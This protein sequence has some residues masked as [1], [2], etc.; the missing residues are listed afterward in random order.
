[1]SEFAGE[2]R[3]LLGAQLGIWFG[4]LLGPEDPVYTEGE[5]LEIHGDLDLDIFGAAL[6]RT[7]DE[8]DFYHLRFCG[9]DESPR[10]Y[11]DRRD[12]W[13]L[14]VIDVSAAADP[15]AAA[16]GWMWADMRRPVDLREG[17]L[18]THAVFKVGP[19][20]FFWY[21]SGHHILG[22]GIGAA[23]VV[24]RQAE[25]YTSLLEGGF[26]GEGV[27]E[28]LSVLLD[29][30]RSYRASAAFGDDRKFWRDALSG[31]AGMRSMSGRPAGKAHHLRMR[32]AENI[33]PGEATDLRSA[34]RRL[35]TSISGLMIAAAS[36]YLSR[37]SGT[38]DIVLG[39][40][41]IGRVGS[42]ERKIPGMTTNI[43]PIRLAMNP[44]MSAEELSRQVSKA[45]RE[46]LRHQRYRFE[47]MAR[48][49][50]LAEGASLSGLLIN[51]ISFDYVVKFGDCPSIAHNLSSGPVADVKISVWDRSG[52]GSIQIAF[53]VNPDIYSAAS[54]SEM[55]RRF[56][57]ILDWMVAA[58]PD[59]RIRRAD[60]LAPA[61]REQLVTGWNDTAVAVP[62]A[63][64]PQLFAAQ[65]ARTPDAVAVTGGDGQWVTYRELDART[66]RLA[67]HLAGLGTGPEQVVAVAME[68]S[69]ELV[70]ALLGI[71]KAGAAYLPVDPSYPAG[72][73]AHMLADSRSA[74]LVGTRAV[75]DELPVGRIRVLAV[76]DL[77]V[78]GMPAR[79]PEVRAAADRLAYVMYTSGSTGMPKGVGITH[80]GLVNYVAAVPGRAG[81]GAAGGRYALLQGAGTDFGNTAVYVSLA[82]GGVLHV[83]GEGLATDP[84]AVAGYLARGGIDYLKVVPSHLAALAGPGG[85]AGLLPG[86]TLML[87]GEAAS[88]GWVREL[89]A[90]AGGRQVVNH[91]GP[92]ETTVGVV[93]TRLAGDDVAGG[94]VPIGRPVANTRVFVLD[95]WLCPVPVGVTGELYV[96][97]VQLARGYL[98]RAGLTGERFVACPFPSGAG[99]E[100]MYRTGDLA[101]WTAGGV[102]VFCGRADD[103][104]KVRGFRV[105]PGEVEAVLAGHPG[106]GQVAVLVREDVP[107]DR[108]LVAYLVPAGDG[109]GGGGGGGDG[110][111]GL[112]VV[113]RE[114]AAGRLPEYM[115][116]AAVVILGALP[117]TVN[118]KLD[119]AA[120]P[121]P[122]YAAAAGQGRGPATVVEELLCGIFAD[123]LGVDRVGPED[124]FFALGG[125]SLLAVRLVARVRSVLGAELAVRAVFEAPTPA[126]LAVRLGQAGPARLPLAR[127][128]RPQRV[129]LSFA[130]ARLWFI[131]QLEGPSATYNNAV[132]VRLDGDLD[133]GALAAALE[134]VTG[135]HEVLRTVFPAL[136][137]QPFQQVLQAGQPGWELETAGA[138]QEELAALVAG[139][140]ARPFDLAGQIPVRAVLLRLEPAVHVLVVVAHHI[141]TDGWSMG[142]LA[143]DIST[144]YSARRA[145]AAPGWGPLPVQYADYALWQRELLGSEEDPGSVLAGQVAWWRA[146][147]AQAPGE[148]ALPF[149]RPRPP[150]PSYRGH[151]AG[152]QV[153]AGAH[154][155]LAALARSRGVTLFMVIQAALAVLLSKLGAGDDIPVGTPVAGRT[156]EALGDLAG[157]FVNTLV[158]RTS[159]AGDPSFG[160]LLDRVRQY[161]LGALDHQDVPFER[162]V[163]VLAPDRSLARHPLFQVSLAVQNNA[164]AVLEL[165]GL[166]AAVLPATTGAARFDLQIALAEVDGGGEPGGLAG[167]V[168]VAADVFDQASARVLGGRLARLLAAVA[169]DPGI[170]PSQAPILDQAERE[171]LVTG[172]NDTAVAVPEATVP[173]LFAAQAARTP[174]AIAVT[175]GDGQWVTYQEL[176][177]RTSRLARHLAGLGTGPEQVVAVAMERSAG[178]VTALL[179]ILKTGAA[180]LPIDAGWPAAWAG[181]VVRDSGARVVVAD[182]LARGDELV[183]AAG[184]GA[185]VAVPGIGTEKGG[186]LPGGCLPGQAAYVM[187]TSGST[188][189]PK[190]VVITHHDVAALAVDRCWQAVGPL[191]VLFHAPQAFDASTYELWVPLLSG[192]RLVIAPGGELAAAVLR[193][194][195]VAHGLTHVHATA[196]LY[197]VLA[198]VDPG[199]F[200]GVR[201]V[202]TGGDVVPAAAVRRVLQACAGVTVR[203]LY[204]PTEVTMACTGYQAGPGQEVPGVVPIGA[205]MDNVRVF[206]LDRWLCPVPAGVAGEL[207]VAGA[208]LARGYLQ[209]SAL[210][211]ERFTACPFGGGGERMYRTGDLARWTAGGVLVFGGRAD[212]QVKVRGFRVEPGEVEAV[213]AG[214]PGVGQVAVLV[215]EDVP[216]D[217]RLVAY[218]VPAGDGGGGGGD[219][220]LAVVVREH[221]ASRLP[222]YMVPAAVVILG[223][224]PLTVNGKLDRAALPAPDYAA[225]AGQGQNRPPATVAE[226]LLCGIFADVL[227]VDRVGPEDDF[228]ALGGHSLLAVRLISRVRSVVGAEL[229]VRAVFEAPTPAGLAARLAGAGPARAA[230]ARR[231]RPG[232]VPLS[233]AQRRLWFLAQLEGPSAT[234]NSV[235]AVRLAGDLDTGAL[236]VA[237]DDVVARHE[238]LRTVFPA[239]DG[240][241]FQQ[242]LE[243][244]E[245]GWELETAPAAEQELAG[246]VAGIA[247][248]PFDLAVQIPVRAVLLRLEPAVHVLVVVA[249][250]IATD[251]WSMGVLARDISTAYGARRAGAAPGWG[252]L[253][254]QYADYA[255]WQRELL[256]S[257]DDPGSVLAGQVAWWRAALAGAP[258]ELALPFDRPR[259]PVPS[260]RGHQA[261]LQVGAGAH[262]G[263]AALARSRGVTLFMVIQAA[264]AVLLS[265]LGAGDDI[266]VGTPVAGRT[267]EALGDLAGFFVNTLV[268]RTSLAGD[269]SFGQLL[270]R[271]R[272][273]WLGALDHQ[274]VPFERL[275]EVLAPDRSLARHPLFQVS[276][277]V[278][279]NA[280]AVLELP[281]LRAAVLPATTGAARFD[282]QI[283]LAEVRGGGEP[284]GLA[285]AVT[286][287]AD[288]FD[289]ASARVLGGRLAR[290]LAAVAADPG[291]RPSQAPIL[292]QAEREQLVTGWNDTAVAV[293]EAT[294]PQLFAAQAARTPD[295]IAVT[296]GDRSWTYRELDGRANRL[297][298]Y[299]RDMGT[300][301]ERVVAVAMERSAELVTALL[302][303]LKTGAA[304][305]PVD[306]AHP[307]R[308]I[309][310]MLA[311]AGAVCVLASEAAAAG[312]A[313]AGVPVL[314][315]G[316]PALAAELAGLPPAGLDDAARLAPL[317]PAHPAYVIYTSGSTGMPKGVVI[318]HRGLVNYLTWCWAAY[319]EVAGTSLL[320]APVTFDGGVTGLWGG[321]TCGGRVYVGGLDE[322][323]P[324]LLGGVP[325]TFLKV[326]PSHL[327]VLESLPDVCA[328]AGRLMVGAET[329]G[330]GQL[331]DWRRRHPGVAVV[332][333]YGQTETT[334]GCADFRAGPG[335]E[336]PDVVPIGAPMDNVRMFVLDRWLCPVPVG[337]T[338]ELYVA[339]A[340]LAR[341]YLSR[342]GLTA[343]R[344]T[345][346]PAG[347]GGERM[348][349]TGDLARWT[350]GG[351][352]EFGG[353]ADDQV[354]IRGFRI[355]PGEV[356]A[357][358]AAHPAVTQA[359]VTVRE[360]DPGDRRLVG[361]VVARQDAPAGL[362]AALR[363]HT[364]SRLP[365]YMV[366]AAVVIMETLPLTA[367]GKLD[368]TALPA[369]DYAAGQG[370][371]PATAAEEL[372]CA[373]FAQV[374]G[375]DRAGPED[376]FFALGGHSLLAVRLI[377]RVRSV[378]GAELAVRV[379]FEAPTPAALA[380]RLGQAGPARVPLRARE[381]PERVPLSF[382]QQRLWFI[383]QLEGPSATYN[384]V[385]AVRLEGD[386]DAAALA[387]AL[388]DVAARHEVLR[389]VFPAVDGQ[390]CQ[391]VL[392]AGQPGWQL[393]TAGAGEEQL[394]GLVAGIAAEPFDLAAQVPLRAVL[395]GLEPGVH[396]LVVAAH[397]IATDGW[398]MGILAR[399]LGAAYAARRAGRAPGWEPLPVQYADYAIWQRELLGEEDDP[400]SLLSQQMAWWRRALAGVPAE[401]TLPTDRP[402]SAAASHRGHS[403]PLEVPARVHEGLAVLAREQG[404]TL[405]MVVQAALAVLLSKLG[406]GDDIPVGTPVAGRTDEA[407]GDL[408]GFFVNTLVLRTSLAGDP[409]FGQLLDRVRQYWLGALDHQD[410]P[411]ERL[412]EVLAPDRSLARHPL[413][414]VSLAV[415]N[416]A[417]AVLELPG[418]RAAVLPATTGAAR[419]DLQIALAEVDGGGE[420]GGLAGAV[421]VAAD[422]FDQASARVLG[423]RLARLLAA[424]AADP[425]IRPSQA[426]IL[427]QAE[428]EQ[429]VT[430]WNDTAV[431]V[432]EAT[433]P[434]LFAAQ[435]ARTPDAIAVTGGD[436]QWVTYQEL[437]ARTSRLARHLAGLG[438]GPEQVV[439][440]AMERSAELVTALL[441]ILK[442]GAAYLPV[443]PAHPARRIAHMLADA[444]AVC[445]L[446]SEAAAAGLAEAGVPVLVPGGPA[447]AAELAGLPPA[448][449]DDAARLAPLLPAHP[450]YVMYTSGSTGMPKGVVVTHAG[451]VR[452]VRGAQEYA[453]LGAGDVVGQLASVSFDA[454]T[455]EI[456][457]ALAAGAALVVGREGVWGAGELGEFLAVRGVSVLWL[458][459][460][461]FHQVADAD[462]GVFSGLRCLLAG[463]DV[464][465][466][467][468]CRA[469]LERVPSVRLVNGY[470]PTENTTFTATHVVR[471]GDVAGEAAPP[472]GRP[473]AGTRVFVLDRWLCPV[474]AGVTGELYVAG[475][476]LARGYLQRSALTAERFTACP[477]GGGGERMYRTGDLARWTAGGVLVFCGRAD[478]QVKVRGFRVEPGEVE[479]V[480][481][482]HPGV[483][484]VA[485]LVREDV[486]GDRRLVA[487][488]VPARDGDGGGDGGLAVVVRQHAASRLPE[489]MVPAAVVILGA[490][491]LTVNG[492]LD[493]AALPAP[494]Y[495]AAAGQGQN[496]PPATVA[497][498]LLCAVFADVLGVDRVGPEDDFFA[499]GGHSLLAVRL[500]AR[501]RSVLGAELAVR[502]VFEAPTPAALAVR[503]GQAGPARLPLARRERPQRVPLSFAQARLWFIA[504]LEGPSAT[505][506]NAVAVRLDGDLD[507]GALAAALEDVTGRHEVLRTVFP[508]LG[509]QP[510]QQVLQAGQP[511]WELETA[512]AGQEELAGLVAG[513]AARPFD[514]AG[515]IPV[516]AVLLRLE[517]AVHVL[518]VVAHH[519]ATDGWSMGILARDISTAYSARRAGAAP[520]WGPLPVQYADYALWQRE[521][522]GSEEDPGS[523]LAGQVAWWRAA[524]AQAPGEL[525]LPFDRP[526]PPVP[527]YRGHQAGLQVGAGAHAGLAALA[528]SRGVT[529]FMVIQAALAVL[530]SKLGAGDDIP[531]GTPV[532]GRTDEALG[533][534][535]GFFVNTL[536]LR[537]S[538]AGDPS[539]GQLLDR[540]R[541][542]WLGA[543]DHQDVP[544]ER[545]VEVLAPDRSLARHP[546]FQVSLAVQNNAPAVLELP[547]LRAAVLPATT[548][549]ARFDLQIAL[550]EVD[551]GGEPGGLAGAVT[552]AADVF[553][554]ASARVLGGRLARL[555]AA[556]AADPGIRPSQAPILDQAEREQ[557]V[558]GW[559]DTA[560]AVPE[561][562]V[563]QLFAAQAART[564]DAIAVT[565]GDGQ[566]V[567]YQE[568]D[569]RTSR[570]ARHLAGLGTGPEQVVAV[571]M[572]RSA[573]L[574]TALLGI[575]KTGAAY[576][577]VD[578][579]H[580][581]RR[582]AHMLADARPQTVITTTTLAGDLPALAGV[583]V[584]EID[585]PQATARLAA[586]A[587]A[588]TAL[589]GGWHPGLLPAHPAYVMYTSGSTGMP[590]GVVV[591]HAGVVRLVRG[592]QEYARLGAGDVVGQL[593]SVSFDAST[594]EIWGALAAGAA[595]VVGREGVW[596]AGELGEFLAVRGVSVLW[597]TAGLFHQV[598]DADAGVFSGLRCLLAGGDVLSGPRCRAVLERVPSVRLVNGYGPTENT[599]F[600]ATHVVR[601]GDVAG[602]AAPPIGRPIA[603]TRVFVLDRWL[604]PVPAGVTGELYVAGAGLARG[605]LQRSALTAERFTACPFGGGGERMY[606]TGDLARWTAGGVLV[607]CGRADDQVKV[608]GFRVEPGE[609]EAVLAGHP[610]VGQVAVLVRED[611]PGDRRLVAYLVPAGDPAGNG[612]GGGGL[613]VVVR[614]HAAGRLPEYMV[615]AAVVILGALPLTVN[616]KLDRAALPAPD[617][618]AAAGQGQNRPPATV[619]EELLCAVFAD[620]LGVDRVGPE[621]DFFALGGHS[622]LAV[623]LVARVRSVL[624]AELAVRAVFEAPTPAALAVRLGQAGPA[625]LPLARRERPQ[626]VPLSF[627][628]ARLWFIA[629]LEG[630]SAT[631]NNAVAVRLDGDLDA[632]A[633]AAALEDV[634]GRHEVLRTVFPAL[635]G[636]P[637]QQ[638]L[639][640]GQPGWELE[641][642]GAGQEELAGLVAGIAARPFDLAG[643]I[644]VRA[645]LLRLEPAVHVLVVVAHH[646]ATDG[647]SMGIL[648]RDISTAYSARRAGAAPG[649]GPLPVQYADYALWQR[650]LLGSEEDPGSVL[651]GQVAWWRAALAQAPG[652][653]ALPFDRPRPPVPSYRGH[654]A[655]L[656]VPAGAHAQL[657]ALARSRGVT[658]FMV[659]QAALAVLLS[660]LGAGDDIPVG[661]AVAGRTDEAL[662]DLAGFFVNTLVLRTSLAGDPSFSDLL[663]RVRQYWL[664]AL[665]HQDVP[666]ERLVEILAPQRSVARHPLFQV[667]L[668]VQN[669]APAVLELPG[670]QVAALPAGTGA[671]RFDL[672][673]A[674]AEVRGGGEPAGLRGT[675]IMAA[676]VFDQASARALGGRLARLLAAVAADPGIRPSQAPILTAAEREQLVTGWND[677]AAPVPEAT[678]PQLFAAQ[679]A[680]TPDA[681]A[682]C[683]GGQW[684]T[685]RELDVRANRL[686]H[687]LRDM[688][689][690]PER[691]VA[692]A[693][694]RSAELVTALL[695]ILRAGAAYLPVDPR[696]P[697]Q[698]IAFMLADSRAAVLI[699]TGAVMDDLPTGWIRA[700]AVDD[701]VVAAAVAVMSAQ[702]PEVPAAADRAAYVIYTSGSTGMPKGVVITHRGLVNYVTWAVAAYAVGGGQCVPLHTS[703]AFDLTVT[704]VLV[705][706][707]A[708]ATVVASREGGPEGLAALLR[709]GRTSGLV[710]VVPAHLP[711]LADSVPPELLARAVRRLVVGGEALAGADVRAWLEKAPG[712]AVV[713]EYGP[714]EVT[715]GCT[716]YQAGPGQEVPG[717]VPIGRPVANTRVFVLDRWLYPVPVGV[718][719]ELY[720]AGVQLA[721]GYLGRAELTG[722]RFTACPF[723]SGGGGERMYRTGDL[724]RWTAG[725]VLVFCG[726][727]DDQ[728]K[729]RGFRVEPG[730]VEAVLAGHPGVGQVAVLVRE[731]VPGDRRLVAYLVPAAL[732]VAV[733]VMAGWRWWCGSTRPGGCRSTWF[734]RRW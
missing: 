329:P 543:L 162:L 352:L 262:A 231:V 103:Q 516:R 180:Y 414:Q 110:D 256:G 31:F 99:G 492:K 558:T 705:P 715:V 459:A 213:L 272:Q 317:L 503:L 709:Q 311:D 680:R 392:E 6:R 537:T 626:R 183:R 177:A 310:H 35:R 602:E 83:L 627:A 584:L 64:V 309:A 526:R 51:V 134:D 665:D 335:Q 500:V 384:N 616:G 68:R 260:Y 22:D 261:G 487:Y 591:T 444:G 243:A 434:Q 568:L 473:I 190:G 234:Y 32:N 433:V 413:F 346:C 281:G 401:L 590:K 579:A 285:G 609:V 246:L 659:I 299:L 552:V 683:G 695:G 676:D 395:L 269:P 307:A 227:G 351:V 139:I 383:A 523:V 72:R 119:R 687:Y 138:G 511:G 287:A 145:G 729:V 173:Q 33:G 199:C 166:R 645:V 651:A 200:T 691:V 485:V 239:V 254:V 634:T 223:A 38:E 483:G 326:T 696:Y 274:D 415:Q 488:L 96:A 405:F 630:P 544:F 85:V 58:S 191:R 94:P 733:A 546:L 494:D 542:Y 688:G 639:Q 654:Q 185:V 66:S 188:G 501:V 91:Y 60:I 450:A 698:R 597:L 635:G 491:P 642:A 305:L 208:G 349:R 316:G 14:H 54:E 525:A 582:I 369:P 62:E 481:A 557:L 606:R 333:H 502:A 123:V 674:L 368:R 564:P 514:L 146:A 222:E 168:T 13:Q 677:T 36:I 87:G 98:G 418:L 251:G 608:R 575:L 241:P 195:V 17:Q 610:G 319:P 466:G 411:F 9:D 517:P 644:P 504:Q 104:V 412:V 121:A 279:N 312:L 465:S 421:T 102:L 667:N 520:G 214:H 551:G 404:V 117:L 215:R 559:N 49:L 548:G 390:P 723:P 618:A 245:L 373:V 271:V 37:C 585:D 237:L 464:L 420:P 342:A 124:D 439:A 337:V 130:Q 722:E 587:P 631:Y 419:F 531:V 363:E 712:S 647:W 586:L 357:V 614:Q 63:T 697:A 47:D 480:L 472:I 322:R 179:G 482:G 230:L 8:I 2:Q 258:G 295:A 347:A 386:L 364:A 244:G 519:I 48:D 148:L 151:Q 518:V 560:V 257:E 679:A 5:Y 529:L 437:D 253:P 580:P 463:G 174:D 706:L 300:G 689:A 24:R 46:G 263:L 53:D 225:A 607:F 160:Q 52:D 76:D 321:L 443:D 328:P 26:P 224:L 660:K 163:E 726:R 583:P 666:F 75:I 275:V 592:A 524:L 4:Q 70:T 410:V 355:E 693:I 301:P 334:V 716:G 372:L 165:P 547:G 92:T 493:R 556:V 290:L 93:L 270:D 455:F 702:A 621:D 210:T 588:G 382:A 598:A 643:Q 232:R 353:R 345:A 77:A 394:P 131:A 356:E 88:P 34:A 427:D 341:G 425:G 1:M 461:L 149:D 45:V 20:R 713:N 475:A 67:R 318:T 28:P 458:T 366:P 265:K 350:P 711:L 612:G 662:G 479:A 707:A 611:V 668:D 595:L 137:G 220:G 628:Q 408:V 186:I 380:V 56:R 462:A 203:H 155:Q 27:P 561:A 640:A 218:L 101:R 652:E 728:V 632:G 3:E 291:I 362:P 704:S 69:A 41:V 550:A 247:A 572:E 423:G 144:A 513:I 189:V 135:R 152:L 581:A 684:V 721:R 331:R 59:D 622:L 344:F 549:A 235:V 528:R 535:A 456:W 161:W 629:Q 708:G 332:N 236:A 545:L 95:R 109:G 530:L 159:L 436:G 30:E 467:P 365:E 97:G 205:P 375:V 178:L 296:G 192:G 65:A 111:G 292:D 343:Q 403:V 470:G 371:G 505:Y 646:I 171:Q 407:L 664:G 50:R 61:E 118:G 315:P 74:V 175:G 617:Y 304:Y 238:V 114:H 658:L 440:V 409:S 578:P 212:D 555:L 682:V 562:T 471:A 204:G 206:V 574:V 449:L 477:F 509:G 250:H 613:A 474:P 457:G 176:D 538:L 73:I 21:Q 656:H 448:G 424:V 249:H 681:I 701:L 663:D 320:H 389:T 515:Q 486:P 298:H 360:D 128:E 273:Y 442:T 216:G 399:D 603:G 671:A 539:F 398:S 361:Y 207:Y 730:E 430:G 209:R 280:P 57:R 601:A 567:T 44:R 164:P 288:V 495:A 255:L 484:Q 725:G 594:F 700:L 156:D 540:V 675:V 710:K 428:R 80:R 655:G 670:L 599:T 476:G 340:G 490:L 55:S 39:V 259:P 154:A 453:R 571:A 71:L 294:V 554:Q 11:V 376:D 282:L 377:S 40:P 228:F 184:D 600:T 15:R 276:L 452:L 240:E 694:E 387:A 446:A 563:P 153:P 512:G 116:P 727:A 673:I 527:S 469:V 106:V 406:A 193:S 637:F 596:G 19:G 359:A 217:R 497:E 25:I 569:A 636:Q 248:E 625:R 553:D 589:A 506:N 388:A 314:V 620:V 685:Y 221:A 657:A 268:L 115:V 370:R 157:F 211:A 293:P 426:P 714:T 400:D 454:S 478:D 129:P 354:K 638:V 719:G 143:R 194:L 201:E 120:L 12:G 125:H 672:Q 150:V 724:A 219:G 122:D 107:G 297:A 566:W 29:S 229:A 391:Q 732:A 42:R 378:L 289:Q 489:Y 202:L 308:R 141:A 302:G 133:A 313:E 633:L 734:P 393:E 653:L 496:R 113:V 278:Q 381:R 105:E 252:P 422:V 79:A 445:V 641:T 379:L 429:L 112:A 432:P 541:Q 286:V 615:P 43:L 126:A 536:V 577:P 198:E 508:A 142:I 441:G 16:E 81:L 438:T 447:L 283:A 431:A 338:G 507:A 576:L 324:G 460:G 619:A 573:G 623:R 167:A 385:V 284:G 158:L 717:V 303:I 648:A 692:V 136:G 417:P 522:L 197:R 669:N 233:F 108:R 718:T 593:A 367:N 533:D 690:G 140:A 374:L 172:W 532:A 266:P 169:A 624:G 521:L 686:A 499:L 468:R 510:F 565:G 699:G 451:V 358:L 650:E 649:W 267:D 396:V 127:R 82:T 7:V 604:C 534:L 605:Y 84:G 327:A 187:Y 402:R 323:L 348:Y 181:M 170:R 226:E 147:L 678:V 10:Q 435:A 498:E 18:F 242:V 182:S 720:V 23:V 132:A 339:G 89:V 86:R 196:G 731:D 264:L 570:L 330:I 78:A 661:T 100:R 336:L 397:H 416:N 325:L 90:A 277:A 703:L 306:P